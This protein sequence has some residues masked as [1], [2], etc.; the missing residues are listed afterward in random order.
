MPFLLCCT[1]SMVQKITSGG[2]GS[3]K[4]FLVINELSRAVYDLPRETV[5]PAG[6][7]CFSRVVRT[8][9]SKETYS[10]L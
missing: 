9:N 4:F 5:G 7:N 3:E 1:V 6:S 2:G 10:H 8:S